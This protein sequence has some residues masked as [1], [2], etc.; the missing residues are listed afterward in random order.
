VRS[1]LQDEWPLFVRP[2]DGGTFTQA[3]EKL[4]TTPRFLHQNETMSSV[5]QGTLY[6]QGK[7]ETRN[8]EQLT[9]KVGVHSSRPIE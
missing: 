6:S 9:A 3:M 2:D 1:S 5:V 7:G 8:R 4:P